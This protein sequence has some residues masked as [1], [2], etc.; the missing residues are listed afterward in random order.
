MNRIY[1][2]G[3][4]MNT[5]KCLMFSVFIFLIISV[6][7]TVMGSG[8][9]VEDEIRDRP[10]SDGTSIKENA[11]E[12]HDWH[13]LNAIRDDLGE[14]Y[15][16][17]NDLD[18]NTDGYE[19]LIDTKN[20]WNPIGIE[21]NAFSGKFFGNGH[22]IRDLFIDRK[23]EE[24]VGLFGVTSRDSMIKELDIVDA[25]INGHLGVGILIGLNRGIV[26]NTSVSGEAYGDEGSIGGLI[27]SNVYG[28]LSDTNASGFVQGF[29]LTGGIVGENTQGT[30]EKS[31]SDTDVQ[32]NNRIG[33]LVGQ[34]REG[35]VQFSYATGEV[36]GNFRYG[37]LVGEN[38]E[39]GT[40][41][42]SFATGGVIGTDI[43]SSSGGGLLGFNE[44]GNVSNSYASGNVSGDGHIGGFL[45]YNEEDG[46]IETSYSFGNVDGENDVGGFVGRNGG[47]VE[48]SY[49]TLETSD[50]DVSDGGVGLTIEEM[51]GEQAEDSMDGFDFNETWK[52]FED[53]H[54]VHENGTYPMLRHISL[55]EQLESQREIVKAEEV[56]ED[57]EENQIGRKGNIAVVIFVGV[58]LIIV[59]GY[60]WTR[61]NNK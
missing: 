60:M 34:N 25:E 52:T 38:I 17:M 18:E 12:I 10:L 8:V 26:E 20:G 45:G 55:E 15:V 13:D 36:E 49:W 3:W 40:I 22:E 21:L 19:K 50:A 32:G 42:S 46:F 41:S 2:G 5:K 1:V 23:D 14:E 51:V 31:Y 57:E 54:D 58:L 47:V 44:K 30:I 29:R 59:F 24:Y 16:L 35:Q 48:D 6:F 33:G 53:N 61:I 7:G 9:S 43:G 11:I 27:G 56:D 37:G 28:T 39:R 4:M